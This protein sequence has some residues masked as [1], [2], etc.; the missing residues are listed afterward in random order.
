MP[1]PD[2]D[3][4][5]G[6]ESR[7]QVRRLDERLGLAVARLP[8]SA[9]TLVNYTRDHVAVRTPSRPQE[10]SGNSL[11]LLATPAP[12]EIGRWVQR[13]DETVGRLGAAHPRLRW[14]EPP[15][16]P[17]AVGGVSEGLA[18]ALAAHGLRVEISS[19]LLLETLGE[20]PAAP[21]ELVPVD[22]PTSGQ[23][24]TDRRWHAATV[25][26]RYATGS[27]PE[28]W[29]AWDED[30]V[31]WK[32]DVQREL[33][34]SGRAQVWLALRHGAPVGRLTVH[35]DRQGLASVDDLVV[36][37]AHRRLGI[38]SALVGT[39]IAAHLRAMPDARVGVEVAPGGAAQ[40]LASRLG[41]RPHATVVRATR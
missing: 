35:H 18:D 8:L 37:P 4:R 38:A 6:D 34:V 21:A 22:P 16:P 3:A 1:E 40:R 9:R 13:F 7:A 41:L 28:E 11:D 26:Y 30:R 12:E 20:T 2:E 23:R 29:R 39:A 14:E 19:V 24:A 36:H 17:A 15:A 27:T 25:L 5:P 33:A 32:I 31:A 10:P